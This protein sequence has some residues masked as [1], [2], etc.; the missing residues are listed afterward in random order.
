MAVTVQMPGPWRPTGGQGGAEQ[1]MELQGP[2]IGRQAALAAAHNAQL[3]L[4]AINPHHRPRTVIPSRA[5]ISA[6][7]RSPTP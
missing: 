5:P 1:P 3:L 6:P 4:D 2:P 7:A